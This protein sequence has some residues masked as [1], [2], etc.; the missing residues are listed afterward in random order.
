MSGDPRTGVPV[1]DPGLPGVLVGLTAPRH[2]GSE[3]ARHVSRSC[4]AV[5]SGVE[6]V[7][8]VGSSWQEDGLLSLGA[9]PVHPV[10]LGAVP[11]GGVLELQ[12]L[13]GDCVR[14]GAVLDH[15]VER[16][17]RAHDSEMLASRAEL[18]DDPVDRH[19]RDSG[20]GQILSEWRAIHAIAA[21]ACPVPDPGFRAYVFTLDAALLP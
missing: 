12:A 10:Q 4:D 13:R 17:L 2:A 9:Q 14:D 16:V 3:H 8:L 19:V 21:A 6:G 20:V 15:G 7:R 11:L 1:R 18:V 5:A